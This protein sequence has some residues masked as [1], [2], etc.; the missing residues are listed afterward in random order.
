[1]A[2][3]SKTPDLTEQTWR[4]FISIK[5]TIVLFSIIILVLIDGTISIFM[6]GP[7]KAAG[8]F[9]S[10][11]LNAA[12]ITGFT[13]IFHSLGFSLLLA[14]LGLNIIACTVDRFPSKWARFRNRNPA[15]ID[16]EI[17]RPAG[18]AGLCP[19]SNATV[20]QAERF[21]ENHFGRFSRIESEGRITLRHES[22]RWSLLSSVIVHAG[23]IIILI[24]AVL[25][26]ELGFEGM[27]FAPENVEVGNIEMDIFTG[28]G[29]PAGHQFRLICEKFI[30][31]KFADGRPR[32]YRSELKFLK[33]G[34]EV[35]RK[36]IRVNEPASFNGLSFYQASYQPDPAKTVFFLEFTNVQTGDTI[37]AKGKVDRPVTPAP[38]KTLD[39]EYEIAEYLPDLEGFGPALLISRSDQD[40]KDEFWVL[41]NYPD[42]EKKH[43]K[44]AVSVTFTGEEDGYMTGLQVV[45][46]PG[47]DV[48]FIG[49]VVLILGLF[50]AFFIS[51]REVVVEITGA[52]VKVAA[53]ASKK[54]QE[55]Y[56]K[57][58]A[59]INDLKRGVGC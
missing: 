4:F 2:K 23:I 16:V 10:V 51:Y 20:S 5:L 44:A 40:R 56:K 58:E 29:F 12:G 3:N 11:L 34:R 27:L 41:K 55:F 47:A 14:M 52:N 43:R 7:D 53:F 22:G 21:L 37:T 54:K 9:I 49:A 57:A 35:A 28:R 32:D 38:G 39:A 36:T 31:E 6:V 24:G 45:Y 25:T 48:V 18:D 33:D 50:F 42:F 1:M 8:G 30:F 15:G 17:S 26:S 19:V 59:L 13:D 46:D